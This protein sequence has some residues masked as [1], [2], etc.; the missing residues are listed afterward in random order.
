[1]NR[2]GLF[3]CLSALIH[4]GMLLIPALPVSKTH[5][6][7]ID[8]IEL[9]DSSQLESTSSS[10]AINKEAGPL[11]AAHF[12]E[13]ASAKPTSYQHELTG[14]IPQAQQNK[15]DQNTASQRQIRSEYPQ[16]ASTIPLPAPLEPLHRP[17]PS[18]IAETE[19]DNPF[20]APSKR[21][22][23]VGEEALV[24]KKKASVVPEMKKVPPEGTPSS[25]GI[26]LKSSQSAKAEAGAP[27]PTGSTVPG[28]VPGPAKTAVD[29]GSGA[30]PRSPIPKPTYPPLARMKGIQGTVKLSVE[31][32]PDGRTGQVKIISSAGRSDLDKAA[33]AA[34]KSYQDWEPAIEA[35]KKVT[36]W[37]SWEVQF[38]LVD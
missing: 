32:L 14:S 6:P 7:Q 27:A 38:K 22:T 23:G 8:A 19:G 29:Q 3:L 9:V 4:L 21:Q 24:S 15:L 17:E 33:V 13:S 1:M 25:G 2:A 16:L 31:V 37:L 10:V 20:V 35:G 11:S 5:P 18:A 36:S 34:L 28:Q 12:Q 26:G 30:H